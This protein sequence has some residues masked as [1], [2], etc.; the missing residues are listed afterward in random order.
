MSWIKGVF[1]GGSPAKNMVKG[2]IGGAA[3][4]VG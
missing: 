1:K 2:V 3:D 4:V